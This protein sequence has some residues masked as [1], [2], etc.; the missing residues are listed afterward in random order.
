MKKCP[1]CGEQYKANEEQCFWCHMP[2][3]ELSQEEKK[4][5]TNEE[6]KQEETDKQIKDEAT[7][8]VKNC[9][10][11]AEEI[12][13][14]AIK[15]KYCGEFLE[16]EKEKVVHIKGEAKRCPKCGRFYDDSWGICLYC[17]VPLEKVEVERKIGDDI[18]S[19]KQCGG[20]MYKDSKPAQPGQGLGCLIILIG[21]L[22][23]P[24]IIGIPILLFG[25]GMMSAKEGLWVCRNCG[26]QVGRKLNK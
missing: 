5:I 1:K 4:K 18:V 13:Y 17:E 7:S 23:C 11:C 19:C 2:L 25:I 8:R 3:V 16:K 6:V 9:P 24:V 14:E 12:K 22:L 26:Y 15:C 21:I 10:F 20:E